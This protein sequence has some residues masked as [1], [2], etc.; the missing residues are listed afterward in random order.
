MKLEGGLRLGIRRR[1]GK[2]GAGRAGCETGSESWVQST[3]EIESLEHLNSLLRSN[4]T[5]IASC[6]SGSDDAES[7]KK[8]DELSAHSLASMLCR[9]DFN[10][11]S[12][13]DLSVPD[14][15]RAGAEGD[16]HGNEEAWWLFFGGGKMVRTG[17]S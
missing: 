16:G 1:A 15:A 8:S 4:D 14:G 10:K 13:A 3:M 2:A 9:I 12:A 5:L 7:K 11:V 6:F 17:C